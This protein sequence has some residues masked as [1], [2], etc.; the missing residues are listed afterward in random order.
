MIFISG[1][2]NIV[3][4]TTSGRTFCMFF[5]LFGIPF[6][7][8]V[9]AD[10]GRI[11]ATAVSTLSKH[12]PSLTSNW[13]FVKS[14]WI[15]QLTLLKSVEINLNI[16]FPFLISIYAELCKGKSDSETDRK[17]LYALAALV[18]LLFYLGAGAGLLLLW[19]DDWTF[20]DGYYFCFITMTTI[21][22]G[23]LVP[24]EF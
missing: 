7:L 20:F 1:Y 17:W 19:E 3:P 9:I 2:G 4:V 8:T 22:F 24:S 10:L 23:D 11:F 12:L 21:G 15:N 18:F 5:A 6:T 14:W 16:F 13:I